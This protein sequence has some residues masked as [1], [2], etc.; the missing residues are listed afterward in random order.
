[1]IM[2]KKAKKPTKPPNIKCNNPKCGHEWHTQSIA[3][4]VTCP[5]CQ[6]KVSNP[7]ATLKNAGG[8]TV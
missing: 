2:P 4:A 3:P 6:T 7:N 5:F 1:M 8:N